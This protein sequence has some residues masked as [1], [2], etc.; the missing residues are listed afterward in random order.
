MPAASAPAESMHA[1]QYVPTSRSGEPGFAAAFAATRSTIACRRFWFSSASAVK[2][3]HAGYAAGIVVWSTHVPFANRK[4]SRHGEQVVSCSA[5]VQAGSPAAAADAPRRS[6]NASAIE[7]RMT[8]FL[9]LGMGE[10]P[11]GREP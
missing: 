10:R 4:K 9:R 7:R 3:P 11:R 8:E 2:L 6:A 5:S 1:L